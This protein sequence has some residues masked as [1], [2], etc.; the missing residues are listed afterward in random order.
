MK[1][2]LL[3]I[4]ALFAVLS[5]G[6]FAVVEAQR[7]ART[8][9][10]SALGE[11]PAP[12]IVDERTVK[13]MPQPTTLETASDRYAPADNRQGSAVDPFTAQAVATSETPYAD[14]S[15]SRAV[16]PAESQSIPTAA[17]AMRRYERDAAS[18]RQPPGR[19]EVRPLG[20]D[21]GDAAVSG[22][23]PD[24]VDASAT[25]PTVATS[26]LSRHRVIPV[27]DMRLSKTFRRRHW[28]MICRPTHRRLTWCLKLTPALSPTGLPMLLGT[29]RPSRAVTTEQRR[30][31]GCRREPAL[32]PDKPAADKQNLAAAD[33]NFGRRAQ[34]NFVPRGEDNF[35]PPRGSD[36][37]PPNGRSRAQPPRGRAGPAADIWRDRRHHT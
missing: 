8:A 29:I 3:R 26:P 21:D 31:P 30:L 23:S 16:P 6:T 32:L 4:S 24:D 18:R 28:E 20:Y 15:A 2:I 36:F 7:S 34:N 19:G 10:P 13:P 33:D 35:A 17:E 12:F 5:L 25:P 37:P 14:A 9:D 27:I 22:Q 11:E 1:R